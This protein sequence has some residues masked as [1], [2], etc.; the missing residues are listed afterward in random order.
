MIFRVSPMGIK[1]QIV[2]GARSE[3]LNYVIKIEKAIG[4]L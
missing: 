1:A 4:I 2:S 3:Y